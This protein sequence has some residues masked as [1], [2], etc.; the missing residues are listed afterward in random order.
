MKKIDNI[1]YW[2]EYRASRTHTKWSSHY[3]WKN[4]TVSCKVKQ[5]LTIQP[6]NSTPRNLSKRKK[7]YI[8]TKTP[9]QVFFAALFIRAPNQKQLKCYSFL[10]LSSIAWYGYHKMSINLWTFCD[11]YTTEYY[12]AIKMN[13]RDT[14]SVWIC[15]KN[16][17]L[18]ERRQ[19]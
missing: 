6:N 14:S 11:K 12:S 16:N 9:P 2:Q 13:N 17:I 4:L 1:E 10:L 8:C 7:D 5:I 3:K 18:S 15:L 19:T